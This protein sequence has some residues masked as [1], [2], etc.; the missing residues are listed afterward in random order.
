MR[1]KTTRFGTMEVQEN[2]IIHFPSGLPGFEDTRRFIIVPVDNNERLN[3]LQA[4]DDPS[5]ALLVMDPFEF[6]QGYTCEIPPA[7]I[8]E[9]AATDRKDILVLTALTVPRENPAGVSA[10]LLAPIVINTRQKKAKQV[11]LNNPL[12]TTK[13]N[14][15]PQPISNPA[16]NSKEPSG[17]AGTRGV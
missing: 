3:W 10:N 4:V 15:F 12:Y 9:L 5:V 13:H 1:I 17:S 2:L 11:I 8:E 14:L 6:F 7:E 16:G